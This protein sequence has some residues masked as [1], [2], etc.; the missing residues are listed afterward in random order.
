[1]GGGEGKGPR[2][3]GKGQVL[4]TRRETAKR[5]HPVTQMDGPHGKWGAAPAPYCGGGCSPTSRSTRRLALGHAMPGSEP[6]PCLRVLTG[7]TEG[8]LAVTLRTQ[9]WEELGAAVSVGQGELGGWK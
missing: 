1:M 5:F 7:K 6:S 4:H 2:D 8:P 3:E 9:R